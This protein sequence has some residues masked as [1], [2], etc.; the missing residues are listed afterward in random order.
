MTVFFLSS[1]ISFIFFLQARLSLV[2]IGI[3]IQSYFMKN[4]LGIKYYELLENIKY[5]LIVSILCIFLNYLFLNN[6]YTSYF[7]MFFILLT[8]VSVYLIFIYIFDKKLII[9]FIDIFKKKKLF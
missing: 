8:F 5:I 3:G 6:F 9:T 7:S 2:F 1:K 4:I